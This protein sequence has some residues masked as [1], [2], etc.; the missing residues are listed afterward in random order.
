MKT[1][2]LTPDMI[3]RGNMILVNREH[4]CPPTTPYK[5]LTAIG[6]NVL[7]EAGAAAVYGSLMDELYLQTG[8]ALPPEER[9]TAVS[10]WRGKAEQERI[11]NNSL[12]ENGADFTKRYV[13]FPGHS[14]HQTGLA[15]DLALGR[16]NIDF[17]RPRFPYDGICGAFRSLARRFGFVE[18]YPRDKEHITGI[19][20]EPWH[21]RYI[22]APHAEVMW[23]RNLC[24][25]EYHD[26]LREHTAENPLTQIAEGVAIEIFYINAENKAVPLEIHENEP[27]MVSGDNA[28]GFFVTVWKTGYNSGSLRY[29]LKASANL[30]K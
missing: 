28:G 20:H 7:L 4:P 25:E 8:R 2:E 18:R 5:P 1:I 21:F 22:G 23:C 9:I 16:E 14:E 24:L 11:Y 15:V 6:D 27:F 13:A 30:V 19:A 17:L 26:F 12:A 10:G 3:F 29:A